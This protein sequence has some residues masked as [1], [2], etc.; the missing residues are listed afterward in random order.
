MVLLF[1]PLE[2]VAIRIMVGFLE[3]ISGAIRALKLCNICDGSTAVCLG[4]LNRSSFWQIQTG[5]F[6]PLT[7]RLWHC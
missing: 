1:R 2:S 5:F 7:E 4:I 6:C 3:A